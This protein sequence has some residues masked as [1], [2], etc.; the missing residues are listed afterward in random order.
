MSRIYVVIDFKKE[1]DFAGGH[2]ALAGQ[3]WA[4]SDTELFFTKLGVCG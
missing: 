3:E 2:G 4:S 1:K